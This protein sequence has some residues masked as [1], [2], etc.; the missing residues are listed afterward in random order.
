MTPTPLLFGPYGSSALEYLPIFSDYNANAFWFHGF[1]PQAFE[2]CRRN[3]IAPCV[4]F[5]TFRADFN[6]HPELIPISADGHPIR[7]GNLVQGVCLSQGDFIQEIEDNLLAGI[8][9]YQP[10]GI[11]LD[12]LTYAGWFETPNP[13]LQESCFC[14]DC[15]MDFCDTTGVDAETPVKILDSH[16]LEWVRHKC[17]RIARYAAHY[18]DMIK[19]LL[20]TCI[21]GAYMCP[22]TPDEY[23]QALTRIFAQDYS[24]LAPS[25]DIFTPLI[26]AQKSGRDPDWGRRFLETALDFI[27]THRKVMLILDALDYPHSLQALTTAQPT[28]YGLQM[29]NGAQVFSD[30]EKASVFRDAITAMRDRL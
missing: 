27:P 4:E 25:I 8:Q 3:G 9:T 26:Y 24:L 20:P 12:Y 29:F 5:K 2:A 13:D 18:A 28:S 15:I 19:T 6:V 10:A 17:E 1:N 7:Y 16:P 23:N 14:Q 21:V 11:W 22:W 30:P